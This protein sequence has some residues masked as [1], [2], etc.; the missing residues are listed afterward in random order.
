M[1]DKIY[2]T[3]NDLMEEFGMNYSQAAKT[4]REIR[5]NGDFESKKGTCIMADYKKWRKT[6]L[7]YVEKPIE[8]EPSIVAYTIA[9]GIINLLTTEQLAD[10]VRK[11]GY[12]LLDLSSSV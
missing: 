3:I 11:R 12:M 2:I 1:T 5:A 6:M 9:S 4:M 8:T 7:E 10:L